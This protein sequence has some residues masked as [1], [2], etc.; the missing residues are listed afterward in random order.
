MALALESSDG[1]FG[2]LSAP[3][4]ATPVKGMR[5]SSAASVDSSGTKDLRTETR[6]PTPTPM[7]PQG[8][9]CIVARVLVRARLEQCTAAL[10]LALA[11]RVASMLS[12]D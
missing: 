2:G 7:G 3:A 5:R 4:L 6:I 11:A 1:P 9:Q 8:S 12:I 10:H